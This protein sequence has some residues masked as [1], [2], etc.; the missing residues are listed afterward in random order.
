LDYVLPI[1]I[2]VAILIA[3]AVYCFKRRRYQQLQAEYRK[4]QEQ[5]QQANPNNMSQQQEMQASA[6]HYPGAGVAIGGAQPAYGYQVGQPQY[7][8]VQSQ[9]GGQPGMYYQNYPGVAQQQPVSY[10][11]GQVPQ[12]ARG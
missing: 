1:V 4:K 12:Q 10:Y 6:Y 11:G 8:M 9:P 5:Y 7:Q 3:V 2:G